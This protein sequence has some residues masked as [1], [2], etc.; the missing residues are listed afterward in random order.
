M[1][2]LQPAAILGLM[3]G[4]HRCGLYFLWPVLAQDGGDV[5]QSGMVRKVEYFA[6]VR[7]FEAHG[8]PTRFPHPSNLYEVLLSKEW[9]PS[10]CLLPRMRI[11]PCTTVNRAA[12]VCDARRAAAGAL[13]A[14]DAVRALRYGDGSEPSCMVLGEGEVR[15]GV[16]KLGFAW[17][18]A[19]VRMFRGEAQLAEALGGIVSTQ[20]VETSAVLVQ[21]YCRNDFEMRCFV[22]N[23]QV[24]HVIYSSFERIDPDGYC[25]DFVKKDRAGSIADW[26]QGDAEAMADAERKAQRLVSNW[27]TWLRCKSSEAV[28]ASHRPDYMP[29]CT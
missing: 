27:L 24:A 15:R 2:K 11:P 29:T 13:E 16:V 10:V 26:L 19:H 17:E 14:L 20:G 12:I 7:A 21:D 28:R 4:R 6:T 9:Q 18:A 3:K 25:R 5:E 22:V 8:L 1:L 23:G